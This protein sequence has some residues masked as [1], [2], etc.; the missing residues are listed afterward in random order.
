MSF[1]VIFSTMAF[2]AYPDTIRQEF[3]TS[4]VQAGGPQDYCGCTIDRL[5]TKVTLEAFTS[6]SKGLQLGKPDKVFQREMTEAASLCLTPE[7]YRS[8]FVPACMQQGASERYCGCNFKHLT[9]NLGFKRLVELSFDLQMGKKPQAFFGAAENAAATCALPEE[10]K[11]VFVKAC[12]DA[13]AQQESCSCMHD[14][15]VKSL[16]FEKLV[17]L[18]SRMSNGESAPEFD[19]IQSDA[20]SECLK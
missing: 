18:D 12:V 17:R 11:S 10:Y 14:F 9:D 4:C 8:Q 6:G 5:E 2:A 19:A 7:M 3:I 1:L 20:Q 16:G 15:Y 13:G